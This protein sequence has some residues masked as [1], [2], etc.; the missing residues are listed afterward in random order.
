MYNPVFRNL[1][2]NDNEEM[3]PYIDRELFMS[4]VVFFIVTYVGLNILLI[5]FRSLALLAK[6]LTRVVSYVWSKFWISLTPGNEWLEIGAIVIT[7]MT[8]VAS[9][10]VRLLALLDIALHPC[11]TLELHLLSF[12]H[13]SLY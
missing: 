3:M 1:I 7:L 11:N 9:C 6:P 12:P 4:I 13:S 5:T 8:F 10:F 2:I